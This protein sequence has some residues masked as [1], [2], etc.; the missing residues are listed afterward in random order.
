MKKLETNDWIMLN[1]IIYKIYTMENFDQMR[2]ELME[3]LAMLLDFDS[4]DFY[5]AAGG[6]EQLLD[7]PVMYHCKE[8]MSQVY[9]TLDYSRGI[10]L[11]GKP[12]IYRE[13]D[14]MS[15]ETRVNTDYYKKV[16][17][18]NNWHYSLQM[19]IAK[20]NRFLGVITFYRVKG[21]ENFQ[22]DD[23]FILDMLKDHLAYR[24]EQH[25]DTNRNVE[26]KLTISEAV[27][28]YDLTRREKTIL[29][30]LMSGRENAAICDELAISANTLK[31]HILNI[32]RKLGI[33]NRVQLFKLVK[34]RE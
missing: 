17:Q 32:Y 13:T 11:S 16:Y 10:M 28:K 33:K 21:K 4:A 24:L 26:E 5:L 20:D 1:S 6:S 30:M 25:A 22:Y 31:K 15:D 34:E 12:L 18:P 29:Q 9:E 2:L 23:I 8:D 14:I 19:I 3:D 7:A 27:L